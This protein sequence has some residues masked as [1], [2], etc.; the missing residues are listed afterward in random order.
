[1][2]SVNVIKFLDKY[3]GFLL[4]S[5]LA[6]F[7]LLQSKK[8]KE[9][10]SILLIQLW[11]V[12]E[13][14]LCLPTITELRKKYKKAKID[15]LTTD[16]TKDVFFQN[17]D[18][19]SLRLVSLSP[20]SLL[21]FMLANF[22]KYDLIIDMEEYLNISAIL[23]FFLGKQR[24]GYNH[25][26]R[27][28]L[29]TFK[30]QYNDQQHVSQTFMDLLSPLG[31]KKEIIELRKLNFSKEDAKSMIAMLKIIKPKKQII[32]LSPGAA[33]SSKIRMWPNEKWAALIDLIHEKYDTTILL[34]G[35]QDV[36]QTNNT[37][38]SLIKKED[39]VHNVAGQTNLRELFALISKIHLII[40]IDSG[41]M[42]ISA[43]QGIPTIGLFG[44]NTPVR[45]APFGKGNISIYN[46]ITKPVINV[47]K[48]E[49]PNHSTIDHMAR[50][51][52]SEVME[53][54]TKTHALHQKH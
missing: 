45:F 10:K 41:P 16:R 32:A 17:K 1:M 4:C 21:L 31:I 47:H 54:I 26:M 52:V 28:K 18:I 33:E 48:G 20:F 39:Q 13:T 5:I 8:K 50:V 44:P 27:C 15:V 22:R 30:I 35:A 23:A 51:T 19:D 7:S 36:V 42:H 37:I 49:V 2:A 53:A 12:G 43:A 6:I 25:G 24:I 3:F 40:S 46:P 11:G 34:I 38:I 29:Y 14:I 9:Y